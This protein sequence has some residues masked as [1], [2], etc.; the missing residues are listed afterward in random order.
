MKRTPGKRKISPRG[1]WVIGRQFEHRI[2]LRAVIG[3][4]P[5]PCHWCNRILTWGVDLHV[6]HVNGDKL[7]NDPHNIV[8]CCQPCNNRRARNLRPLKAC[9]LRGHKLSGENLL[10]D[11][12]GKRQCRTCTLANAQRRRRERM[13]GVGASPQ[14]SVVQAERLARFDELGAGWDSITILAEEWGIAQGSVSQ[15]LK[16][17]GVQ[18]PN[19]VLDPTRDL[20]LTERIARLTRPSGECLIWLGKLHTSGSPYITHNS[21]S[22]Y[23]ARIVAENAYGKIPRRHEVVRKCNAKLCVAAAHLEVISTKERRARARMTPR[24]F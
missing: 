3:D 14:A 1:Y 4:E 16:V 22:V 8:P 24:A 2:I 12:S 21:T 9:C 13:A 11:K 10:P 6:D 15:Y 23:V 17:C 20:P 5:H 7:D 18:L 19:R